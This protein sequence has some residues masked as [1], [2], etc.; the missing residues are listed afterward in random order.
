MDAPATPPPYPY[1]CWH[2]AV[3]PRD[4]P[5]VFARVSLGDFELTPA[6]DAD[7]SAQAL[8]A[9]RDRLARD[10]LFVRLAGKIARFAARFDSWD[11]APF[12]ADDV[13]QECYLVYLT[14]LNRWQP[15]DPD[16]PAGFGAWFLRVYP[17]WLANAVARLRGSRRRPP[18]TPLSAAHEERPD[19]DD[20]MADAE[21]ARALADLCA[22][23][24]VVDSRIIRLRV[25]GL[26]AREVAQA[27][28]V[29][30]R[31]VQRGLARIVRLTRADADWE[32]REAG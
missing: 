13:R 3:T 23:L 9:Q 4:W 15:A 8:R 1:P 18:A 25:A 21:L 28:G 5:S 17:L 2:P 24:G 32:T 11:I 20:G 31:T 14:A 26:P 19:P 12:D 29:S 10:E 30:R 7:L 22:R 16:T 27:L 6:L